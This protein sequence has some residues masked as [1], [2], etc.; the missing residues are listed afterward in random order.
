MVSQP[1][2]RKFMQTTAG[3]LAAAGLAST[4]PWGNRAWGGIP[5]TAVEWGPPYID[6]SKNVVAKQ[7]KWDIT[8]ELHAG[9]AAAILAKIKG[10]W[11]NPPY[12][13]V[14]VWSPVFNS[15]I[16]EGW[17][18]P[19]T[20]DDVPNLADVPD[21]YI[22]KDKDGN[23][24]NVP[25]NINAAMFAAR[26]DLLPF[27]ITHIEDFLDPRLKGKILWPSAVIGTCMHV[28]A[29]ALERGGDEYNMEPGWEFLKEIAK[30]GNIGRIWYTTSDA[31]ASLSIGETALTFGDQGTL[32]PVAKNFPMTF[33]TKTDPSIKSFLAIEGWSV[34]SSSKRKQA[35]FDF[36]NFLVSPEN[37][38]QFCAET[39]TPPASSK[40]TAIGGID[41]LIFTE[42]ELQKYTHLP[43]YEYSSTQVDGWVKRF[44]QEI[45]PLLE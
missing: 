37:A 4:F 38:T 12:D 43:D 41:H 2:R 40:A 39:T 32:S 29:L 28:V 45:T 34:L 7:D 19:I 6:A 8:W 16:R 27:E 17:A 23:K 24:M 26:T 13:L 15:M 1:N 14:D 30:S 21:G 22:S 9:G 33:L 5:L 42:E 36:L 10:A 20:F 25:R 44:E 11:P 35:A 3:G 18:E 31:I